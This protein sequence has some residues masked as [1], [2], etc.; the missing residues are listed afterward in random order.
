[1]RREKNQFDR[2]GTR[3]VLVGLG[4]PEETAAFKARFKVP[5]DMIADPQK[6]LFAAFHLKR[7]SL[8]GL[9]S[10]GMA[11]K[12][13]SAVVRGHGMGLPKGDVRQL[14]GVFIIDSGGRIRFSHFARDPADHPEPEVLLAALRDDG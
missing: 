2:L 5:F 8:G 9:L 1:M 7:A 6:R 14:P 13:V 4:T 12:G 10:V 11:A 3:V